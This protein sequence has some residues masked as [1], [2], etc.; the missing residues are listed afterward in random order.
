MYGINWLQLI[1]GL[2]LILA[3]IYYIFVMVR[4]KDERRSD[5]IFG[6]SSQWTFLTFIL[7]I[8]I[9]LIRANSSEISASTLADWMIVM[10]A[11]VGVVN[12]ISLFYYQTR[13]KKQMK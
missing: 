6:R 8:A 2:L 5:Y 4:T 12:M 7:G 13:A 11:A 3:V 10:G 9:V 1:S